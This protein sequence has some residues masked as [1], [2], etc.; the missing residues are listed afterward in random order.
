[1]KTS[2]AL[3]IVGGL[4]NPSKMPGCQLVYRPKNVKQAASS[5]RLKIQSVI[6]VMHLKAVMFLKLYKTLNTGG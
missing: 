5:G 2:E 3:K 6:I 4:S 1:M